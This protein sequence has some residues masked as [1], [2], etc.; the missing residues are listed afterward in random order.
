MAEEKEDFALA[1][2]Q[3]TFFFFFSLVHHF[4]DLVFS[5]GSKWLER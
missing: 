4:L 2:Q 1:L 3:K 5:A